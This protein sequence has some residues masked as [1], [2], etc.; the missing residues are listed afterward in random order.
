MLIINIKLGTKLL[1]M[2]KRL[3]TLRRCLALFILSPCLIFSKCNKEDALPEFYFRCTIDGEPYRPNSCSNCM[4]AQLLGDTVLMLNG[5]ADLQSVA[6]G[7][8]N[9]PRFIL[10]RYVLDRIGSGGSYKFSTTSDDVFRTDSQRTGELVI[11]T[12]DRTNG[13]VSGTFN[14]K[15]YN[16]VQDK[17]TNITDGK[18]RLEYSTN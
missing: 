15:A 10:D 4:R 8:I 12:L 13:I 5:N 2:K 14:F 1:L 17:I 7:V 16:P 6:I 9:K 11:I 3:T 18:F